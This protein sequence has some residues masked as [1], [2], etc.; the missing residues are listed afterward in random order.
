MTI[1][2]LVGA[3]VFSA[4]QTVKY[5]RI[6]SPWQ[7]F[8]Q[9][10]ICCRDELFMCSPSANFCMYVPGCFAI[11]GIN[12][13]NKLSWAHKQFA[14]PVYIL[15]YPYTHMYLMHRDLIKLQKSIPYR[16]SYPH[17]DLY[18]YIINDI[19]IPVWSSFWKTNNFAFNRD[20]VE[21]VC[22]GVY[23][24]RH[25]FQWWL[26]SLSNAH[27]TPNPAIEMWRSIIRYHLLYK[28]CRMFPCEQWVPDWNR[29]YWFC[30]L[31]LTIVQ[32]VVRKMRKYMFI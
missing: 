10:C 21:S 11:L 27:S 29:M 30:V 31:H 6:R 23:D 15:F 20:F 14:I 9:Q 24:D 7:L 32:N 26:V 18:H 28:D 13:L 12:T 16:A 25:K 4:N 19:I 22:H 17:H 2:V 5:E 3:M 1:L 8:C